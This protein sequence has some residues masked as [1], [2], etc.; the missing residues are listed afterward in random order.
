MSDDSPRRPAPPASPD[1]IARVRLVVRDPNSRERSNLSI[2]REF[3]CSERLVRRLR[4][5]EGAVAEYVRRP[6]G[7]SMRVANIGRKT[8]RALSE[9]RQALAAQAA[10]MAQRVARKFANHL[11]REDDLL[12]VA[13]DAIMVAAKRFDPSVPPGDWGG[14]V[15][16]GVR[17]AIHRAFRDAR[18]KDRRVRLFQ[19]P[20]RGPQWDLEERHRPE[21]RDEAASVPAPD[22]RDESLLERLGELTGLERVTAEW[23]AGLGGL[24]PRSAESIARFWGVPTRAALRMIEIAREAMSE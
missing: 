11:L 5:E 12:S 24:K 1:T 8:G 6:D 18:R 2:A 14:Y 3:H 23:V 19:E 16:Y 21:D 7:T 22:W 13:H 17:R 15:Y 10:P 20:G 4:R 9:E